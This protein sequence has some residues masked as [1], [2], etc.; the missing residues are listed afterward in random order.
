MKYYYYEENNERL[1]PFTFEELKGLRLKKTALVWTEGM[2][3]WDTADTLDEL[4]GILVAVPPPLPNRLPNDDRSPAPKANSIVNIAENPSVYKVNTKYDMTYAKETECTFWGIVIM[5]VSFIAGYGIKNNEDILN[6]IEDGGIVAVWILS[7]II[8]IIVSRYVYLIA[9][10]QNRN[11]I[12]WGLFAFFCPELSMI[13][14]GQLKKLRLHITLDSSMPVGDQVNFLFEKADGFY[15]DKRYRECIELLNKTIELDGKNHKSLMLRALSYYHSHEYEK[16]KMDFEMLVCAQK[17]I[18]ASYYYLGNIAIENHDRESA[19]DFWTKAKEDHKGDGDVSLSEIQKKLDLYNNFSGK[20]VLCS[21]DCSKK[22]GKQIDY[23]EFDFHYISGINEIDEASKE[24][25]KTLYAR[26]HS[27]GIHLFVKTLNLK[28]H[29]AIAF[30]EIDDI[31]IEG[32]VMKLLLADK[33]VIL[34]S[35]RDETP[36]RLTIKNGWKVAKG[37][38]EDEPLKDS[39]LHDKKNC[40]NELKTNEKR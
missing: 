7:F 20:Y 22:L 8:R 23:Y 18:S 15:S 38:K 13:I 30:Y 11:T 32:G 10:R 31:L 40:H 37:L 34:F 25:I 6:A 3:K 26:L 4:R 14:I 21:S 39:L 2:S 27:N 33:S 1:G 19:V 28:I 16:S 36:L 35:Y 9:N 17:N 29:I 24:K 5:V 12:G